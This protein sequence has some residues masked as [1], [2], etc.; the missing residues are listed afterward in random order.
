MACKIQYIKDKYTGRELE[1]VSSLHKQ[2][3]TLLYDP[4]IMH[5]YK[6][7]YYEFVPNGQVNT[8]KVNA[9]RKKIAFLNE[10]YGGKVISIL[11]TREIRINVLP[12]AQKFIDREL[13]QTKLFQ[14]PTGSVAKKNQQLDALLKEY[15]QING[16]QIKYFDELSDKYH[17]DIV[18]MF[19][20]VQRLIAI[21][22]GKESI[23]TLPEEVS[24]SL[25]EALGDENTLVKRA[26]NLIG[27]TDYKTTLDPKYLEIYK[28]NDKSLRKE[29]LGKLIAETV[30]KKFDPKNEN[31]VKLL[32]TIFRLIR[33]FVSLF[34]RNDRIDELEKIIDTLANKIYSKEKVVV[35]G[36]T[37]PETTVWFQID[38]KKAKAIDESIKKQYV[39]FRKRIETLRGK[40]TGLDQDD[41]K[42]ILLEKEQ[43]T[44]EKGLSELVETNNKQIIIDLATELLDNIENK[45]LTGLESGK[46]SQDKL[47]PGDMEYA[48]NSLDAFKLFPGLSDRSITLYNRLEPFIDTFTLSEV[49]TYA[50]EEKPLTKADIESQ[51][52]DINKAIKNFGALADLANYLARTIGSIIKAAQNRISTKNK[53]LVEEV[54]TEVDALREYS[55]SQGID[56]KDMYEPFIQEYKGTTILT[57]PY[58]TE[59]Y[60]QLADHQGDKDWYKKN[61]TKIDGKWIPKHGGY[62][63]ENFKKIVSTPELKRFYDFHKNI[64]REAAK[65]LPTKL[66]TN[67]IAN[68]KKTTLSD[69]MKSDKK[70][71]G[72]LKD[73]ISH[74]TDINSK[75]FNNEG[76]V[77]N[78]EL[79][80]DVIPLKYIAKVDAKEKSRDLGENLFRFAA[81][82]NSYKEMSEVLPK[83]RLL[84][85]QIKKKHFTKSND[86]KTKIRG[87]ESNI[88]KMTDDYIKMQVK[89]QM[90]EDEFKFKVETLYDEDGNPSGEKYI[91]GSDIIDFGLKY[92]S[93]LRIGL[94]PFNALTNV[95]IGDIGNIVE[96][97]GGRFYSLKNLKQATNVFFK[98]NFQDDSVLNH[99]LEKL[100]PLQELEDYEHIEKVELN[101]KITGD[102]V[103]DLMYAPQRIGEKFLQTRTMIAILI[104]DGYMNEDGTNTSKAD[105]LSP[106]EIAKLTDKIQRVNQMI[107]GRYSSRDA[108][109][110]NQSV[111][112]RMVG[113]FK[114]WIPAAIES[115]VASK[116]YD[117][118]LGVEIEGRYK[119]AW[120]LLVVD[121]K[122]TLKRMQNGELTELEKYNMRKNLTE[123]TILAGTMLMYVGLGGFGDDDK[124]LKQ[125]PYY[126]FCMNQLDRVS[127]DLLFFYS[128]GDLNN[129]FKQPVALLKTTGDLIKTFEAI[130]YAFGIE[131]SE[132]RSGKH[133]GENKLAAR[134][135][136]ITPVVKP[137]ADVVRLNKKQ[138]YQKPTTQ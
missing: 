125:N 1:I 77:G 92:N 33:K 23:D 75:E 5:K 37:M 130:P 46:I 74:I 64:T 136:D 6:T 116:H 22:S 88:F 54:K 38:S 3:E 60:E 98:Q 104:H 87:E 82:A 10:E 2:V 86:P 138:E 84:Q 79:Y 17:G 89:G 73:A 44:I 132:F 62:I 32:D 35:V 14:L 95:L 26:L 67:F 12:V 78:E 129:N 56:E 120:K 108:A 28:N 68:I 128:P 72:K 133:K 90:K 57:T 4:L 91:H 52:V 107:H 110:I 96:G 106:I 29:Y 45:F 71:M 21:N 115:R 30:V 121:L 42:Y 24:H 25:V 101:K 69:V 31:E 102:K 34:K 111:I 103:K 59:W 85:E 109:T 49:N 15:A 127:G 94:N 124:K 55:K 99:W 48:V 118:R 70:L 20:S 76:F 97:V 93:L 113:Q 105:N 19:D 13:G 137:I 65:S 50:T 43:K 51:K 66:D 39:Y 126:K 16:I 112:W 41:P 11:P 131:G 123:L 122:D 100:N 7:G 119:T 117:N 63:N 135:L 83:T 61:A 53:E 47:K 40:M 134:L 114:K 58:S 18:G 81:F 8:A 27:R 80:S 36:N 9:A